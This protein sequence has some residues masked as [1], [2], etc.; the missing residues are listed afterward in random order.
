M[1]FS[2]VLPAAA[3]PGKFIGF[4]IRKTTWNVIKKQLFTFDKS[5]SKKK[6]TEML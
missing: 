1:T 3:G 4:F 6:S 2:G 5:K